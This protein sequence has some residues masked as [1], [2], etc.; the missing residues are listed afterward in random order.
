MRIT[1]NS[2]VEMLEECFQGKMKEN[3]HTREHWWH[4]QCLVLLA[5]SIRHSPAPRK[6][7]QFAAQGIV[8]RFL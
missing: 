2:R 4:T 5:G 1:S 7:Q 3:P 8:D 6:L